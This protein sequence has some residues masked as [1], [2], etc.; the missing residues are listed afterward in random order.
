MLVTILK[1]I[2]KIITTLCNNIEHDIITCMFILIYTIISVYTDRAQ[3]FLT[4]S[5]VTMKLQHLAWLAKETN[6]I[7]GLCLSHTH[8]F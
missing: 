6:A 1:I 3:L 8:A 5:N 4:L 2:E 7:Q